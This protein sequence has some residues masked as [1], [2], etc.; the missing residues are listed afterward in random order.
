M[1][2]LLSP[3]SLFAFW[4]LLCAEI[5]LIE[6]HYASLRAA[7]SLKNPFGLYAAE[8]ELQILAAPKAKS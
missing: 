4:A 7:D 5:K 3:L 8:R 6:K 1:V 2:R